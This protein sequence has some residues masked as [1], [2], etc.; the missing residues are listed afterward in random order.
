MPKRLIDLGNKD[1]NGNLCLRGDI[2]STSRY[3]A[4]SH[5]WKFS[6]AYKTKTLKANLGQ[7]KRCMPQGDLSQTFRDAIAITRWLGVRYLWIDTFCIIQD[8]DVDWGNQVAKMGS[9]YEGAYVTISVQYDPNGCAKDG[10]FLERKSFSEVIQKDPSGNQFST[11]IKHPYSHDLTKPSALMSRGWCIQERLLSPRILHFR[12]W[13]VIFECFTHSRCECETLSFNIDDGYNMQMPEKRLAGTFL[14]SRSAPPK[15]EGPPPVE[16]WKPW[17]DIIAVYSTSDLSYKTDRLLALSSLAQRMPESIFGKYLAG[18][19]TG[20]LIDQLAWGHNVHDK[21]SRPEHYIAP[22]FSW[23]SVCGGPIR[24]YYSDYLRSSR[25]TAQI[26][27]TSTKLAN[28]DPMGAVKEGFIRMKA[29]VFSA[30]VQGVD[31]DTTNMK[32]EHTCKSA[33]SYICSANFDTEDDKASLVKQSVYIA[34]LFNAKEQ[35]YFLVLRNTG[36]REEKFER[37]GC[38]SFSK[39]TADLNDADDC[40]SEAGER[41]IMLV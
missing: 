32:L 5:N 24:W 27:E 35:N 25:R 7:R 18:L 1:G 37:V 28:V 23:A 31:K 34:E 2:A 12:Q 36:E 29:R 40:F 22:S 9:I 17:K 14:L 38:G 39:T 19:W 15:F 13:E 10:C 6:E 33:T 16:W 20:N 30:I 4:L 26:I 11:F 8:C 21:L 3:I 41:Y